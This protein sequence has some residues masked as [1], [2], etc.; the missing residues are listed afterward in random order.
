MKKKAF[1]FSISF[2]AVVIVGIALV[3]LYRSKKNNDYQNALA[4]MPSNYT[5]AYEAF[6]HLGKYA[7]SEK[8]A[9][10][11]K[12]CSELKSLES[13]KTVEIAHLENLLNKFDDYGIQVDDDFS[14]LR[15]IVKLAEPYY[16][17]YWEGGGYSDSISHEQFTLGVQVDSYGGIKATSFR[18]DGY[19]A[20]EK[21]NYPNEYTLLY[22]NGAL[23][24]RDKEYKSIDVYFYD[25]HIE[26][27]ALGRLS[28]EQASVYKTNQT[29]YT[30]ENVPAPPKDTS[31]EANKPTKTKKV[32]I[33]CG[34]LGYVEQYYTDN[35]FEESHIE[36][37]YLCNGEG[38]Y[39][40]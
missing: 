40:E 7:E 27:Y 26:Y 14:D 33:A 17:T 13:Y 12:I 36:T 32:C 28:G 20:D 10:F 21:W 11:C 3:L 29:H 25:D 6:L 22:S 35:I 16:G 31:A 38:Y 8:Y 30:G 24:G 2:I 23:Y 34:G 9:D 19:L 1:V 15:D 39:Y 18:T 5:E 4:M 37:C